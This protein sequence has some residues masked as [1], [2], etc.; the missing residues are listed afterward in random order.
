MDDWGHDLADAERITPDICIVGAGPAA[1]SLAHGLTGQ[2]LRILMLPG[3]GRTATARAQ[4]GYWGRQSGTQNESLTHARFRLLG[5]SGTRWSG[6][7]RRLDPEDFT[8]KA[9]QPWSGWPIDRATLDPFYETAERLLD[10][11]QP[12]VSA[13]DWIDTLAPSSDLEGPGL[14]LDALRFARRRDLSADLT[15]LQADPNLRIVLGASAVGL[16]DRGTPRTLRVRLACGRRMTVA[17][18]AVVLACGAVETARLLLASRQRP[19]GVADP[20]DMIGRCFMD[21]PYLFGPHIDAAAPQL[22]PLT[23]P[24][25]DAVERQRGGFAV[26]RATPDPAGPSIGAA[27]FLLPRLGFQR[28]PD[29]E[30]PG[31]KAVRHLAELVRTERVLSRDTLPELARLWRPAALRS[32]L[33]SLRDSVRPNPKPTLRIQVESLPDPES[34]ITLAENGTVTDLPR[35]HVHWR[36][37]QAERDATRD[38]IDRI[39]AHLTAHGLGRLSGSYDMRSWPA[40]QSGGKHHMGGARM[41]QDASRGVVAPDLSVHGESGLY[42]AGSAV[43]PTSGWANPTLTIAALSLRL[44]DHLKATLRP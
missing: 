30:T 2:G 13:R 28:H 16:G 14:Y 39:G 1:L 24:D 37:G 17:A 18:R 7:C 6:L 29:F 33:R 44:A 22:A 43:F 41:S 5:G 42:V 35:V 8:P 31:G 15:T 38:L 21:H 19:G 10:V 3:G 36:T 9:D 26:W 34:R 23:V 25:F 12:A 11:S 32:G 20:H 4:D 27:A 40:S